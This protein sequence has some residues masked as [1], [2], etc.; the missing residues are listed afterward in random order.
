M[1]SSLQQL[2]RFKQN[3]LYLIIASFLVVIAVI[4]VMF[5][6]TLSN[7]KD[8]VDPKILAHTRQFSPVLDKSVFQEI[9]AKRGYTATELSHFVIYK[10]V[11]NKITREEKIVPI[12]AQPSPTPVKNSTVR[13]LE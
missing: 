12:D 3:R 11:Y 13:Y 4:W 2:E 5:S 8:Q 10:L 1:P 7:V 9:A 6:I